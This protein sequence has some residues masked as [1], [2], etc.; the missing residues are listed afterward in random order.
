MANGRTA[1][2]TAAEAMAA[3]KRR[4]TPG[5]LSSV[6]TPGADPPATIDA[7][8]PTAEPPHDE[9]PLV[10]PDVDDDIETVT[11]I[12][13]G[14]PPSAIVEAPAPV[15]DRVG[16]ARVVDDG[17][18]NPAP[19]PAPE[20]VPLP[21]AADVVVI[22][23]VEPVFAAVEDEQA[24][25]HLQAAVHSVRRALAV[26]RAR[27]VLPSRMLSLVVVDDPS[28]AGARTTA[29]IFGGDMTVPYDAQR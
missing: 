23:V 10:L 1:A 16:G 21:D 2:A 4:D 14:G 6:P 7:A 9:E 18:R 11:D 12:E 28:P 5:I 15:L 17:P 22:D 19:P 27:G 13:V 20:P 24:R 25:E 3:R 29:Q 8:A 26:A